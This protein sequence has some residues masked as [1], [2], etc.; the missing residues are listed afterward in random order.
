MPHNIFF[1]PSM[2]TPA[3]DRL[4]TTWFGKNFGLYQWHWKHADWTF[5]SLMI[6]EQSFLQFFRALFTSLVMLRTMR[7]LTILTAVLDHFAGH[8]YFEF[9]LASFTFATI[10]ACDQLVLSDGRGRHGDKLVSRPSTMTI[11]ED[12][13]VIWT[14]LAP[15]FDI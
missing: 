3:T 11:R 5:C 2:K 14:A 7:R 4:P 13:M 15:F 12:R 9:I 10:D 8:A 1:V 6:F